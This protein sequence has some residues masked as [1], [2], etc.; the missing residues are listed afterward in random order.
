[1]NI[2]CTFLCMIYL[3]I[4]KFLF[5]FSTV[6]SVLVFTPA[7][8]FLW[9][10]LWLLCFYGPRLISSLPTSPQIK[11]LD[12]Q[13]LV[14]ASNLNTAGCMIVSNDM[15]ESNTLRAQLETSTGK[16]DS[17]K[18]PVTSDNQSSR[19]IGFPASSA[20]KLGFKLS[21]RPPEAVSA[22][23]RNSG[24]HQIGCAFRFT[25]PYFFLRL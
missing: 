15:N 3:H 17:T 18:Y 2:I 10:K 20:F 16:G 14:A 12:D 7:K 1:M 25:F 11:I 4:I 6:H 22:P 19:W 23:D 24:T 9:A 13:I 5:V 8:W 21:H